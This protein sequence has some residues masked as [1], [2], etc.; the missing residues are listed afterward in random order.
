MR[1]TGNVNFGTG[2]AWVLLAIP[3][4]R[5]PIVDEAFVCSQPVSGIYG[6][7]FS[8]GNGGSAIQWV[9]KMLGHEQATPQRSTT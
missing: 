9:M 2:T 6:Q 4:K 8:M 5:P 3:E 1:G 7:M